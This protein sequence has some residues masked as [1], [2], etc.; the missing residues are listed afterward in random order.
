MRY[1][2]KDYHL[3]KEGEITGFDFVIQQGA[4]EG[5]YV[6]GFSQG[7]AF[8]DWKGKEDI[9]GHLF[10]VGVAKDKQ[11]QGVGTVLITLALRYIYSKGVDLFVTAP[12][13][14][15]SAILAKL[16]S[17][18]VI[19]YKLGSKKLRETRLYRLLPAI[20]NK[21][22]EAKLKSRATA[23][24]ALG[25]KIILSMP[26]GEKRDARF[27]IV[28]LDSVL[29]SHNEQTFAPTPGYPVN[30]QGQNVN[31][32][33]Y[34]DDAA[35]QER[36]RD[37]ARRLDPYR[38][39]T[40]SRTPS[41]SPIVAGQQIDGKWIV[42]S[43][44]NRTMST[45]LAASRHPENYKA[46]VDALCE[47]LEAFGF[48]TTDK[49][50][51][52][53]CQNGKLVYLPTGDD[54]SINNDAY[55]FRQPLLVRI[56]YGFPAFQTQELA[57]YNQSTMKGKRAVDKTI[58]RSNS[59][60]ENPLC[61]TR[62][63]AMLDQHERMSDFYA[64]RTAQKQMLE[65][66]L[67]CNIIT[68]QSVPEYY[69]EGYF[70]NAGKELVESVLAGVVLEKA[71]LKAAE[72]DGIKQARRVVVYAMPVLVSNSTLPGSA[73][74]IPHI[75]DAILYLNEMKASGLPFDQFINQGAL[76]SEK[77]W[78]PQAIYLSRLMSQGQ[79]KFKIAIKA[80][81]ESVRRNTG[82][83]LFSDENVTPEEAFQ[84]YVID[85][86][87]EDE[88]KL[89]QAYATSEAVPTNA[90]KA[91]GNA[92]PDGEDGEYFVSVNSG[93][94]NQML[95]LG[96]FSNRKDA[97]DNLPKVRAHLEQKDAFAKFS[98]FGTVKK[99][100][101]SG[102]K[103]TL[104]R[105]LGF[106]P[107]KRYPD[108]LFVGKMG[109][110][111]VYADRRKRK[112]G[113]YLSI[114]HLNPYNG[115]AIRLI[116]PTDKDYSQD[117][118]LVYQL[119]EEDGAEL[120]PKKPLSEKT[121]RLLKKADDLIES[122]QPP[123]PAQRKYKAGDKV[124]DKNGKQGEIIKPVTDGHNEDVVTPAYIVRFGDNKSYKY[125]TGLQPAEEAIE[126]YRVYRYFLDMLTEKFGALLQSEAWDVLQRYLDS[127]PRGLM[128]DEVVKKQMVHAL[129]PMIFE[130][131]FTVKDLKAALDETLE[132][133]NPG[134]P[135]Y[136]KYNGTG[137]HIR[138]YI[139]DYVEMEANGMIETENQRLS[140]LEEEGEALREEARSLL[141]RLHKDYAAAPF[142][143]YEDTLPRITSPEKVE[144]ARQML[145]ELKQVDSKEA[146]KA[147]FNGKIDLPKDERY[148]DDITPDTRPGDYFVSVH[149][150][151]QKPRLALGPF[152]TH[153]EA[154]SQ[155]EAVRQYMLKADP[156]G[157]FYGY[158]TARQEE[159]SGNNGSLNNR[160]GYGPVNQLPME[161]G[162]P[163]KTEIIVSHGI[164]VKLIDHGGRENKCRMPGGGFRILSLQATSGSNPYMQDYYKAV[165]EAARRYG[166]VYY[167]MDG[168]LQEIVN[169]L[170]GGA[171]ENGKPSIEILAGSHTLTCG[172][173]Y[174][175]IKYIG[176]IL[177][178]PVMTSYEE[179]FMDEFGIS[180]A[181]AHEIWQRAVYEYG[182]PLDDVSRAELIRRGRS[183]LQSYEYERSEE[184]YKYLQ[185]LSREMFAKEEPVEPLE[186][187]IKPF[188]R[189]VVN[190]VEFF[191]VP[192]PEA[193][194]RFQLEF[195]E[196]NSD[197]KRHVQVRDAFEQLRARL[198]SEGFEVTDSWISQFDPIDWET[199][200]HI[201]VSL[202][203][204]PK[205]ASTKLLLAKAKK[206]KKLKLLKLG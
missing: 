80:F 59:L 133:L 82:A 141:M 95:V 49:T 116:E 122:E 144:E 29:A 113:D 182:R 46:Y 115:E 74:L 11:D 38:L 180:Q 184:G 119:A 55:H 126:T 183:Q 81:N 78:H 189:Y 121:K 132:G 140:S 134:L 33:N 167:E 47:E 37:N 66:L 166:G 76:F 172:R 45:K 187:V 150:Q 206:K 123:K 159:G 18:G 110:S 157:H 185:Q 105:Q 99:P 202:K 2:Y 94:N 10:S 54:F 39:L 52:V 16:E 130:G 152:K 19:S 198:R 91:E 137:Y 177:T 14:A 61:Q 161:S 194:D 102:I 149:N 200:G 205:E 93:A 145:S 75:N 131:Q 203:P 90:F 104:N 65:A 24:Q 186:P 13:E 43:G 60:R 51:R 77:A 175:K 146:F 117:Y 8:P 4:D 50:E 85:H 108:W 192:N 106:N 84:A 42:V 112:N 98:S 174:Y 72:R 107:V 5:T 27:A 193:P 129:A 204:S 165:C 17:E 118:E 169:K 56:D 40:T 197:E 7:G 170:K 148:G 22:P 155:V 156:Q 63:P 30:E 143:F 26:N 190:T 28:E 109:G 3:L 160:L 201:A 195:H 139:M 21:L 73:N 191:H 97:V 32:R 15:S 176:D 86:I 88:A 48:S 62:I 92:G 124:I 100:V 178:P 36:V 164:Q 163:R 20:Q 196:R 87:P 25:K 83:A 147:Y 120:K 103:G 53:D 111:T 138:D 128:V 12:N 67:Q 71:A 199:W 154:I 58:E 151:G 89:I 34:E 79:R 70:T 153:K 173:A 35:A 6:S 171:L 68:E 181:V 96:P 101:G 44:N 9:T 168:P 127:E 158:G 57:K 179:I 135:D 162:I 64:D 136:G 69:D 125:E 142:R 1:L 31:D 41:G 114:A 188:E 23:A